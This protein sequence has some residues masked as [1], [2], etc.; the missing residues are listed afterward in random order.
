MSLNTPRKT[1]SSEHY[2]RAYFLLDAFHLQSS[3]HTVSEWKFQ[4]PEQQQKQKRKKTLW[5]ADRN[6]FAG[7]ESG[8]WKIWRG[9]SGNKN[10]LEMKSNKTVDGGRQQQVN[11]ST[12]RI[13]NLATVNLVGDGIAQRFPIQPFR[14][15]I[16]W[17]LA[18]CGALREISFN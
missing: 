5:P 4:K 9:P 10:W 18:K 15:R 11:F 13:K 16:F 7:E 3:G 1:P 12:F 2:F 14:V 6:L 17:Q 8:W